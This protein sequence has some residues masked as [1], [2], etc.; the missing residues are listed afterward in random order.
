M[1]WSI[2]AR[3]DGLVQ[4]GRGAVLAGRDRRRGRAERLALERLD[5]EMQRLML[6]LEGVMRTEFNEGL[7]CKAAAD[8]A[9]TEVVA[10][11]RTLVL[12]RPDGALL[13]MWGQ[14]L[15]SDWR[16]DT[17]ASIVDTIVV[18]STRLRLVSQPVAYQDHRYVAAVIAPL[19]G[20]EAEHA[21][22]LCALA[23]GV[24][25]ALVVAG[26]G[27]WIVGRQT[28][29]PLTDMATQATSITE[30]NPTARLHA[31]N[32]DDELGR[33]AAAF[34]GLLDR[35]AA[36]LHAQRQ[37]MADASHEL[38]TPVSVVRTTAQVT[39]AR[40]QSIGGRLPRIAHHRGRAV[41]AAGAPRRR[42]VPAVPGR[43]AGH[44]ADPRAALSRRS[45]RRMRAGAARL[46][47]RTRHRACRPLATRR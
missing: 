24:L 29:R 7:T 27:G 36:V 42:D 38:R 9:S 34:N 28:L 23:V 17:D 13:A 21:E 26:V 44:S 46:R 19:A 6:T 39:L 18:G 47:Q 5:G 14:P 43:S 8:E 40:E 35:L 15:A 4:P 25:V 20:L 33:F 12:S 30:R 31:P 3:L 16:P 45:D 41:G 2:R 37:F 32:S 1:T 22:L 11:D 10:P